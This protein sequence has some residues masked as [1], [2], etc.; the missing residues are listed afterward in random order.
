[1]PFTPIKN[2]IKLRFDNPPVPLVKLLFG[3][4]NRN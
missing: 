3:D 4:R 2:R 1:M